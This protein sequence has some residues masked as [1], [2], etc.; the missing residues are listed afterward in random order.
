[1]DQFCKQYQ[2]EICG[3]KASFGGTCLTQSHIDELWRLHDEVYIIGHV[4]INFM[5]LCYSWCCTLIT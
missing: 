2:L 1:L 4:Y 3:E 5:I